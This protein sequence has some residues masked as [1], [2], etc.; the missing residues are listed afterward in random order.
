MTFFTNPASPIAGRTGANA[1]NGARQPNLAARVVSDCAVVAG[2]LAILAVIAWLVPAINAP[3]GPHGVPSTISTDPANLPYYALR[4]VFRMAL[5]L[6][7]SLIFTFVYGLAAARSRRL[8]KVLIPLLDILQSVPILGF[9][10]ATVTI[11]LALFP[12]SMMG[13]EAASIFA[14]FTSQAWNMTFSFYRSLKSEPQELVEAAQSL[15]LTRWQRFWT[16]DVPNSMIP[17]IWNMMMSVGGGWFFLT[18]SE[19]ISVGNHTYAL[20]GIGSY[21]AAASAE[22]SPAK[23]GWAILTMIIVVLLVDVCIWKPMTAWAEKFR[24][25]QS[26]SSTP[27]RSF[28]LTLIRQSHIDEWLGRLLQPVGDLLERITRPLGRT[29]AKWGARPGRRRAGDIVFD[30]IVGALV[31]FGAA[32]LLVTISRSTGLGELGRAFGLGGI[33][34]L[35]VALLTL[36]CSVVWVPVGAIIGMNPRISRLVQPLVQVLASFPA[37]FIFPFAVMFFVACG[38]D[39]NWGSILLMALGTQWYILFNVIA[40]ASAIPDDLIEMSK[41]LRMSTWMRWRTLILPAVFG[42]WVTGG[43]TAAGGAW[44]ASIVSEIVSYGKHTLVAH[45]LGSYIAEATAHGEGMKTIIG[46]AVMAIFVVAVNR[47]FWNPL[48][49]LADRRFVVG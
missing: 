7:F 35:R 41:S 5:A 38:V 2:I 45:G 1:H 23:I 31:I 33:T 36:L 18:A 40:G 15:R 19:M 47:L 10:S 28:V 11:W 12:G 42:S 22:E 34:F 24:I 29:G 49:R 27:K 46:V 39:I 13:V 9:L 44:N 14:I 26:E 17:L 8:G 21:V 3:V 48:Q 43:I 37:N 30:V 32:E 6:L 25:T 20:P 4:S 16:L